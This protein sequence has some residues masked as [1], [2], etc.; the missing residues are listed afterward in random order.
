MYEKLVFEFRNTIFMIKHEFNLELSE[1]VGIDVTKLFE[2]WVKNPVA[3]LTN[4][5]YFVYLFEVE[6]NSK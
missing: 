2:I 4:N 5:P 3:I 6:Y 1:F